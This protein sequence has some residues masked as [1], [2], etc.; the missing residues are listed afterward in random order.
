MSVRAARPGPPTVAVV[1]LSARWL[2]ESATEAGWRVVA[3]DLFGDLDTRRLAQAWHPIG[4]PGRLRIDADLLRRGLAAAR[5]AGA[6]AWIGGSGL[7]AVPE[8]LAVGGEALPRWGMDAVAIARVRDPRIFFDTLARLGLAHPPVAWQ[9]PD[10]PA[11]WLYKRSRGC[12]GSAVRPA[13]GVRGRHGDGVFQRWLPG[14]AMSALV[15]ADGQS[16]RLVGLHQLLSRPLGPRLP[17]VFAGVIGPLPAADGGSPENR[18][19][20]PAS[21]QAQVEAALAGLVPAFGLRGLVSLDFIWSDARPHWLEINPR[22]SASL[23]LHAGRWPGGLLAAHREALAGRLPDT[24]A[25]AEPGWRGVATVFA[26]RASHLP[27][28]AASR[29]ATDPACH[30]LPAPGSRFEAGAPVCSVSARADS[31]DALTA[32][33]QRAVAQVLDRL[34]PRRGGGADFD[35]PHARADHTDH[36]NADNAAHTAAAVWPA[37]PEETCP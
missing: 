30:D 35:P 18:G 29:L 6:C 16:A 22:P 10:E 31:A 25:A 8:L 14:P 28:A 27:L 7:E 32:A 15:L 36:H 26:D 13:A 37:I 21:L 33:L 20:D 9:P 3:L 1:G 4:A 12:G 2:A 5:D 23:Q 17:H 24:A 34:A 11:G 19:H